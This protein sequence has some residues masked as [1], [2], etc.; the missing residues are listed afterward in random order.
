MEE[1][2]HKWGLFAKLLCLEW[3]CF[4]RCNENLFF[5]ELLSFWILS[6]FV[7]LEFIFTA[8]ELQTI[9]WKIIKFYIKGKNF[10]KSSAFFGRIFLHRR[11]LTNFPARYIIH[12]YCFPS[13]KKAK[14]YIKSLAISSI[15]LE[16]WIYFL[17]FILRR[18]SWQNW[19]I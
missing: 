11:A 10:C 6:K 18:E 5:A 9:L 17:Q 19:R 16:K 1:K 15:L 2:F 3:I 12:G 4:R 7:L 8:G 13:L 14:I